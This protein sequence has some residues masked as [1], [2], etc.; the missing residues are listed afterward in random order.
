MERDPNSSTTVINPSVLIEVLSNSTEKYDTGEKLRHYKQIDSLHTCVF[1]SHRE[2]QIEVHRRDGGSPQAEASWQIEQ[3][4]GTQPL[5][6]AP[7]NCILDV[8]TV[9]DGVLNQ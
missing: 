2:R 6:L 5:I 7:I 4:T 9:Y 1:V 3:T 8:E